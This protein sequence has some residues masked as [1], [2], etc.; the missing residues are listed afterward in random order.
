MAPQTARD[1]VVGPAMRYLPFTHLCNSIT[2]ASLAL[3]STRPPS[4]L[5]FMG[6]EAQ[7]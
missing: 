1:V 2:S 6:S 3:Q 5:T 7:P 4:S